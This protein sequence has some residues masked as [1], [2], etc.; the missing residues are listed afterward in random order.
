ML[1]RYFSV[2]LFLCSIVQLQAQLQVAPAFSAHMVLQRNKPVP[3]WGKA[4]PGSTVTVSFNGQV[5]AA[6][7]AA[8]SSWVVELAPLQLL[9]APAAMSIRSGTAIITLPDILVGDVWLCTGQSNMEY[10]FDRALKRYAPP[11]RGADI[12]AAE[13]KNPSKYNA[14]RYLYVERTLKKI[15]VLPTNG[16]TTAADTTIRYVSAAGYFFAKELY[17][18]TGIPIGIISSSWGGTRVEQWTAPEAYKESRL[19]SKLMTTDTFR[20]DGMRPGQMYAGMIR[21]LLPYAIKGVC[22]YQGESN[23]MIED[24]DTYLEKMRVFEQQLRKVFNDPALPFYTVQISPYLYSDRKDPK[25]HSPDLLPLFWEAQT[26]CLELPYTYMIVTTDLVDNLKDIHP[27]YKWIVGQRLA[28]QALFNEY[29]QTEGVTVFSPSISSV[30]R[31]GKKLL[32]SF[33]N[34]GGQLKSTDNSLLN[35]FTMAGRD[36]QFVPATAIINGDQLILT[37]KQIKKPKY[38]RFAWDESARPNLVNAAGL[39]CIPFRTDKP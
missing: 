12:A 6:V 14:I 9:A 23:C 4:I 15:P 8:D 11:G 27:S 18:K 5:K 32:L 25:P 28:G 29:G 2:I 39:P 19:F 21:P 20:I 33:N 24:Q 35:W 26:K 22:W 13:L 16:W 36:K 3:V 17:E 37:S 30:K 1:A 31:K 34:T 10:T 7:T 38:V